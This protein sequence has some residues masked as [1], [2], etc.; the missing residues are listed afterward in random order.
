MGVMKVSYFYEGNPTPRRRRWL[1]PGALI[2]VA[3]VAALLGGLGGGAL[4][5]RYATDFGPAPRIGSAGTKL[6]PVSTLPD[7]TSP[8]VNIAAQVGPAVVAITNR[9]EVSNWFGQ[10]QVVDAGAGSGVI[11]D[12]RGYIVTNNH[13]VEGAKEVMVSLG[14]GQP[15]RKAQVIGADAWSD[16][17]VIKIDGTNLPTAQFGD[18]DQL[19]VGELA[20]AIGNSIGEFERTV[21]AGVISGLNRTVQVDNRELTVIQTDAAINPGNSGGPLVNAQG[22]V[23][24]INTVKVQQTGVEGLGFAIPSNTVR[25][26][27]NQLIDKGHITYPYLGVTMADKAE[28][29]M[30]LNVRFDHGVLAYQVVPDGPAAKAGLKNGDI[31]L[32]FNGKAV[33]TSAALK[34]LVRSQKVGD[35]VQIVVLRNNTQ[36]TFTVTLGETTSG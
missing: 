15:A 25:T 17:A 14:D 22:Q 29:A 8:V 19:K 4:A 28:A 3:L 24:G 6:A 5:L 35:K 7:S 11:F 34:N 21:T 20:V 1:T 32:S 9:Q 36:M 23:I 12:N 33:E 18:S 27:V 26:I 31:I 13:V 16:L 10:T 2:A 30:Q